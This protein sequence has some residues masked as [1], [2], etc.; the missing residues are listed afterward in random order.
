MQNFVHTTVRQVYLS[1]LEIWIT[2]LRLG[3][4]DIGLGTGYGG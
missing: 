3:F 4:G 1:S 2:N